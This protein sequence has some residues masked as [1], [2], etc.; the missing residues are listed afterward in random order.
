MQGEHLERGATEPTHRPLL[1]SRDA[2]HT[3]VRKPGVVASERDAPTSVR[4][5]FSPLAVTVPPRHGSSDLGSRRS[6]AASVECRE[7]T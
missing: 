1:S 6:R 5:R 2:R 4:A 7:S 3:L